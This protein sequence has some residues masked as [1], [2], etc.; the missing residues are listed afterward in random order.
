MRVL[1][2]VYDNDSYIH[3]FPIGLAYIASVLEK[4][5][6]DVDIYNQDL[7]H[8]PDKHLTQYLDHNQYDIVGVGVVAGYYQFRKLLSISEA[9]NKSVKRPYYI[10]GGHGPTP[11]PEYFL[12]KTKADAVVMGEG[13]ETIVDLLGALASHRP[14]S[15]VKGIAYREGDSVFINPRR[16]VIHDIDSIPFPAYHRFPM[17]YYRLLRGREDCKTSDFTFYILSGRGCPFKCNFCYRMD[18]G[19]RQRSNESII[20]EIC[21]LKAEYNASYIY[22]ADEVLLSSEHR[23]I[24]LCKDFLK[25][26]LNIK[27]SCSGRLNYAKPQVLKLMKKAGCVHISY[28]IESFNDAILKI[29]KKGLTTKQIVK[30]IESTFDIGISAGLNIIFGNIGE[31]RETL[32][33][34]VDFLIK[35][36]SC[37]ELRTIR[38]VTPYP[39]CDLYDYAIERGLLKDVAD[40]Y[41]NKHTNSDLVSVNFT[42]L[43]DE[44]FYEAF[45]EANIRLIQNYFNKKSKSFQEQISQLYINRDSTFRGFRQT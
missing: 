44:E 36:D 40:F 37:F 17:E 33:N 12:K 3:C 27:W 18:P 11:E 13:E 16:P 26:N 20:E 41:E 35:Y 38:P 23:V 42:E 43:S 45:R 9:I 34:S 8:W 1:L 22:F 39:G 30:G 29:M 7:H 2:I 15:D 5:D 4:N 6:I 21:L 14:L 31:N 10:I 19:F 32:K 24:G 25:A 28:G